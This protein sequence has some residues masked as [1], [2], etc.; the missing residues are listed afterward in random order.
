[1]E[2]NKYALRNRSQLLDTHESSY[3][4]G[5]TGKPEFYTVNPPTVLSSQLQSNSLL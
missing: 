4:M 3:I 5:K 2:A 1:M